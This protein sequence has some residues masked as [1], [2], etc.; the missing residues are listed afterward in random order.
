M[1]K[2]YECHITFTGNME[3]IKLRVEKTGW[4]FSCIDGDPTLGDG[5]RAYATKHYNSRCKLEKVVQEMNEVA[6]NLTLFEQ[7]IDVVRQK[8]ELIVYDTKGEM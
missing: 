7:D 4:K 1:K 3:R 6:R 2:Y 8:V 5:A